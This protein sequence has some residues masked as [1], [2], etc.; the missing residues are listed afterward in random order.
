M[1]SYIHHVGIVVPD[2]KIAATEYK[3]TVKNER[4]IELEDIPSQKVKI[5]LI[6]NSSICIE[7]IEPIDRHSPVYNF[8]SKGGGVHHVCY[9]VDDVHSSINM[10]RPYA[11]LIAEPTVGFQNRLTAFMWMKSAAFGIRLFELASKRS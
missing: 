7:F 3:S 5:C 9:E 4:E 2:A 1:F 10:L 8:L 11:V 6:E